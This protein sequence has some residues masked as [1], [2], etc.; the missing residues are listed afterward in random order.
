MLNTRGTTGRIVL[1]LAITVASLLARPGHALAGP[2]FL[3]DDPEPVSHRHFELYTFT[4]MDKNA[5]GKTVVGPALEYNIGALPNVQ[6]HIVLPYAWN[7]PLGGPAQHGFSDA[8]FGVKFRFVQQ[9]KSMPEIG[10]FPMAEIATGESDKGLGNGHTWFRVPLWIQKNS[11]PWTTYGGGGVALNSAPGMKNYT[12]AGWL[13]QRDMSERLTL[14]GEIFANGPQTIG[15]AQ[16]TYY[17]VGGY[18]K[19][20]DHFNILFSVGHTMSGDSHAIAYFGLYWTGGPA[21]KP[22]K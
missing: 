13:L 10:I 8:E 21:E 4:T 17:N 2:P 15:G 3:T 6:L 1:A 7:S 22:A 19:P 5:G 14:G 20:S 18:L 16:S 11:G 9:T 12:F